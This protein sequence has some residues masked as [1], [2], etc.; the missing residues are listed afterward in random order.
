MMKGQPLHPAIA[1]VQIKKI[2]VVKDG[3]ALFLD[4]VGC[5]ECPMMIFGWPVGEKK[6]KGTD[7]KVSQMFRLQKSWLLLLPILKGNT[8]D[9]FSHYFPSW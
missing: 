2:F 4:K 6:A 3:R 7:A 9:Y 5:N 1:W 8:N